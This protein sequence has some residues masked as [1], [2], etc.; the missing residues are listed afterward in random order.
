MS[1]KI[2]VP[3][4]VPHKIYPR[5]DENGN[6]YKVVFS[7]ESIGKILDT[8]KLQA[9]PYELFINEEGHPNFNKDVP[10]GSLMI[11]ADPKQKFS[12]EL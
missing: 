9:S 11:M 2:S 6:E 3:A 12:I 1:K 7:A 5:F 10:A 4:L 8:F